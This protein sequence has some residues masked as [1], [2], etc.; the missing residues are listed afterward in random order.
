MGRTGR[1][2][3]NNSPGMTSNRFV[4]GGAAA[5]VAGLVYLNALHNPFMYD[6]YHTVVANPSILNVANLQAIVLYDMTRPIVNFSYA[7]DRALSGAAPIGFHVTN[8]LL[9]MLNVV[10]LC[11]QARRLV[12]PGA[13]TALIA[14]TMNAANDSDD[15]DDSE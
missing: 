13:R 3:Y 6:D 14:L 15:S 11:L 5:L 4:M 10:L 12:E 9:H 1:C 2:P 7:N 8:T